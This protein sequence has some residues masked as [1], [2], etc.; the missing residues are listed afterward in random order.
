MSIQ[1][2]TVIEDYFAAGNAN[3][4]TR[5][6]VHFAQNARVKDEGSWREGRAQ[7]EEWARETR[8]KYS[9]TSTPLAI[10]EA[11]EGYIVTAR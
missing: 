5:V 6:A 2:P 1:L 7:I 11:S 3:D 8:E 4:V 9:F 10:E